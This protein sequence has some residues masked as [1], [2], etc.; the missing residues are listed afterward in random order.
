[1]SETYVGRH[2][3]PEDAAQH[4]S[5]DTDTMRLKISRLFHLPVNDHDLYT[6]DRQMH[7]H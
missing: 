4:R 2:R 1:M 6:H 7:R 3:M 5:G